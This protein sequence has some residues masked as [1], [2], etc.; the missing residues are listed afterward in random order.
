MP[1]LKFTSANMTQGD[2]DAIQ[3]IVGRAVTNGLYQDAD[4]DANAIVEAT[5]DI[6]ACHH[7]GCPLDLEGLLNASN[8]EF[9][10]DITGIRKHLNH[11]T[12]KLN[13]CFLPR[14]HK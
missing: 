7:N 8:T 4:S 6:C 11:E 5:M 14:H 1:N 9:G 13:D 12:G 10:H 2:R 3:R